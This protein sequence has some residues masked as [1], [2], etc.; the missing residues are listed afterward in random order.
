[1]IDSPAP[2]YVAGAVACASS[3]W[4]V[5]RRLKSES[6]PLPPSPRRWPVIGHLLSMPTKDE[7]LGF[8]E[9]G[10]KLNSDIIWLETFGMNI[11]VLNSYEDAANLLDKRSLIYSDR[12]CPMMLKDPSLMYWPD[13]ILFLNYNEKWRKSRRMMHAWLNKQAAERF[14]PSQQ[15]QAR[16]LLQRLLLR[17]DTLNSSVDLDAEL[18][19]TTAATMTHSIYGYNMKSANDPFAFDIKRTTDN[20]TEAA[21]LSNFLVNLFPILVHVPDWFPGT[22][23]KRIARAWREQKDQAI[24]S[25]YNWTKAQIASGKN[26]PSMIASWLEQ[27]IELG[28]EPNEIE[29]YVNFV[30]AALLIGGAETTSK[31]VLI[32]FMAMLLFPESQKKAQEEIDSVVGPNRLPALQDRPRLKYVERLIQEALRWCPVIP[33]GIPHASSQEDVYKGYRI[34]KGAMVF[35]NFWAMSR[36]PE[37]YPNP[38]HFNPDRFLDPKVPFA[39]F[40]GFGRRSCPGVHYGEASLFILIA[41]ILATFNIQSLKDEQ[42]NPSLPK[43]F[44]NAGRLS[45][46]PKPFKLK[47]EP[48]SLLHEELIRLGA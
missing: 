33:S 2:V 30:G 17:A 4:F 7:H 26:E 16:L 19:R 38:E 27:G 6:F 37:I 46:D 48:R 22:G 23:W 45:F 1:M 40:F 21:M 35:P 41:S 14:Q 15:Q 20:G 36:N 34:P 8:I 28:F 3:A 11:I 29:R 44:E 12:V 10:K 9:L 5:W 47:L 42:G 25:A 31:T 13:F 24:N 43:A 39:P 18:Y 32:F